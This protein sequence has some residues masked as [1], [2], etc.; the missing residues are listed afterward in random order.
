MRS[1]AGVYSIVCLCLF[2]AAEPARAQTVLWSDNFDDGDISDWVLTSTDAGANNMVIRL[3]N[4][5]AN[6][7]STPW[8]LDNAGNF[9]DGMAYMS[10]VTPEVAGQRVALRVWARQQDPAPF[11]TADYLEVAYR[12]GPNSPWVTRQWPGILTNTYE[13]Y[14]L[15]VAGTPTSSFEIR[16]GFED[17]A[18]DEVYYA[19][20]VQ[21]I[22]P[23]NVDSV[24]RTIAP[25][26]VAN[27]GTAFVS[28]TADPA[29]IGGA[30]TVTEVVPTGLTPT[31][32]SDPANATFTAPNL[33]WTPTVGANTPA[34]LTYEVTA[35]AGPRYDWSGTYDAGPGYTGLPIT[36][37]ATV[38]T[39][40]PLGIFDWHGDIGDAP[41]GQVGG[42]PSIA[43]NATF[44]AGPGQYSVTGAGGDVWDDRDRCHI[45]AKVMSGSYV[46]DAFIAWTDPGT[47][48]W[49]KAGVMVRSSVD[50]RS[51][52]TFTGIRNPTNTP[53]EDVVFQWRDSFGGGSAWGGAAAVHAAPTW[54][55]IVKVGNSF[56]GY[57]YDGS[58]WIFYQSFTNPGIDP[59]GGTVAC[60]FVTSH[61]DDTSG[62]GPGAVTASATFDGVAITPLSVAAATR[63]IGRTSY[64]LGNPIPV[65]I[66]LIHSANVGGLPVV[67]TI[68][69][70]WAAVNISDGG[71][72]TGNQITWNLN[73]TGDVTLTYD[74]YPAGGTKAGV[75]NGVIQ[76]P[77]PIDI[78]IG[79]D[80]QI[81]RA[82]ALPII[83]LVNDAAGNHAAQD[84][85][86]AGALGSAGLDLDGTMVPGLGYPIREID[87]TVPEEAVHFS[88][89]DG[90]C[91]VV[92]ETV[93]SGDVFDH[94]EDPLP[95]IM[96]EQALMDDRPNPRSSMHFSEG[97]AA[98]ATDATFEMNI[99]NI[100]HE[101][102]DLWPLG[103]LR[104]FNTGQISLMQ[105][106]MAPD[107]IVLAQSPLAGEPCLAVF[108]AGVSGLMN[109]DPQD[110]PTRARRVG[111]GFHVDSMTSPTVDGVY[112]YQR[113]VQWAI[114]DAV[115]AGEPPPAAPTA[116]GGSNT[117]SSFV[118]LT[119]TDNSN[120]ENGFV[121]SRMTSGT[122]TFVDI[123]QVGA[124]TTT[125]QDQTS[126]VGETYTY[127]V[128]AFNPAGSSGPSNDFEISL[129]GRLRTESWQLYR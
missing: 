2:L 54:V 93:N 108:N 81:R 8:Y 32:I 44:S 122:T 78:P 88:A 127:H 120:N 22:T 112:M 11:E 14:V 82:G 101:I 52:Q 45:A 86:I 6:A 105:G 62:A 119:W 34:V 30:I 55:R 85:G 71:T 37:D 27:G 79:G 51:A 48:V 9:N 84:G 58:N 35:G 15:T 121:I 91:I 94:F 26:I 23:P 50:G 29:G 66:E 53:G 24:V 16:I 126:Q 74:T 36:G 110:I 42:N 102:T 33:V 92:S 96:N 18:D 47:N 10:R 72:Q 7:R 95:L 4:N 68:P 125:F 100:T 21:L 115:T 73:F 99:V 113:A 106:A 12:H 13:S 40:M 17:S 43:G 3:Q 104:I 65:S 116:L 64:V 61:E 5:A 67:E 111:L 56:E 75:F 118:D 76:D 128:R 90:V 41:V 103:N 114:G 89:A 123:G 107:A 109:P 83:L 20:D 117:V 129:V 31:N 1:F 39:A 46:M 70:G 77:F 57:Y 98:T 60:I 49:S 87:D 80:T 38:F 97:N 59:L 28:L 63:T 69:A 124:D 25:G 19:D